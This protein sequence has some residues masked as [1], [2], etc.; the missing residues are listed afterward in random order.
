MNKG[1]IKVKVK[2]KIE[3]PLT[4]EKAVGKTLSSAV[5]KVKKALGK[6]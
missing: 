2:V 6:K 4:S 3:K 5:R 1:K